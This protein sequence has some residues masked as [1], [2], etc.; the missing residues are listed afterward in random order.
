MPRGRKITRV[1]EVEEIRLRDAAAAFFRYNEVKGLA[2]ESQKAYIGHITRFINFFDD[3]KMAFNI[4]SKEVEKYLLVQQ[5]Q[6]LKSA[7]IASK[8]RHIRAFINYC[9][10]K[11]YM[12][13]FEVIIPKQEETVKE[14]YSTE[15][16]A[17]L[18]QRPHTDNWVEWRSWAMINYFY[19][20]GQRL[21]TVLNI[22]VKHINFTERTV[23]LEHNKDKIQKVMP[24]SK[25][26]TNMLKEYIALSALEDED[27]LFPEYEGGQLKPRSC[28]DA[29]AKYNN[30]RGVT[31][32]SI[33]LFRHTF[34]R[35]YIKAGGCAAK[36]QKLMNHKT[37]SMTMH[38]VNLYG[39]DIA[40]DLDLFDPLVTIKKNSYK[41]QKRKKIFV[42]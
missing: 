10:K 14:P 23:F 5:E 41:Q 13:E 6:G 8:A 38:Y 11:D 15:E 28:Q 1:I 18:L 42:A 31:K 9:I 39:N 17:A 21:S 30:S 36:L 37:I 4:N 35:D 32:T 25:S 16:M 33:H 22:K 27:Y 2:I 34:A 12:A 7:T 26:V 19:G 40:E 3:D 20:T 29:I 24:L